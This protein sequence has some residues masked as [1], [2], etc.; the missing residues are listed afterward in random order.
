MTSDRNRHAKHPVNAMVNYAYAVPESPACVAIV[1]QCLGC[2]LKSL[3][4]LARQAEIDPAN[5]ARILKGRRKPSQVMMARLQ[6]A[7]AQPPSP[8]ASSIRVLSSSMSVTVVFRLWATLWQF[9]SRG[10]SG[11]TCPHALPVRTYPRCGLLTA[12]CTDTDLPAGRRYFGQSDKPLIGT[13][14]VYHAMWVMFTET[15]C[16]KTFRGNS[17]AT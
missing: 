3:R 12:G 5:L 11:H 4:H 15:R 8:A 16:E 7:L 17:R 10:P 1:S 13:A 14:H 9:A 6:V 2:K